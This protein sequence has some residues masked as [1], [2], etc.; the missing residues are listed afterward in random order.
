MFAYLP[1]LAHRARPKRHERLRRAF[2]DRKNKSSQ[3]LSHREN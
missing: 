1:D 2:A 3:A